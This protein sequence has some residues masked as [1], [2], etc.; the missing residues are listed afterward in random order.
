MVGA[1]LLLHR[2]LRLRSS[3]A[4][5]SSG[6]RFPRPA[7]CA[8]GV[9]RSRC[10]GS[11]PR[12][13]WFVAEFGRQPW[14]V[15]GVLPTAMAVS[16]PVGARRCCITLA[17]FVAF[18]TVLFVIEMGLMLQVHPQGP[19]QDVAATDAWMDAHQRP[20]GCRR[21]QRSPACGVTPMIL[22]RTHRLRRPAR[23]LVGAAR[24]AADRLRRSPTASTW[25]SARCCPSSAR[26]TRNAASP[27][28]PSARSGKAT[29]SGSS[30]AAAPSSPPGRRSMR[31]A[32]RASIWRCSSSWPRSSCGR[33]ASST[34]PSAT[35]AAWRNG[36]D[37]ALFVGGA[38]PALIFGVAVGNVLQGVPFRFDRRPACVFYD[39]SRSSACSTR[40]R[41]SPAWCRCR[42]WSCTAPPG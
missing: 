15:D 9:H 8:R 37:W 22:H 36:W 13:G 7:L 28:T 35:S 24:R 30:S 34:A 31:S 38:V 12:L 20:P 18:Y 40:S 14:M 19:V 26:P 25:A 41:C 5:R 2:R 6:M 32:S 27:S 11:P 1:R 29:R 23:D 39:G 3:A 10:R 4:P 21:S 42:C 17:G 33:S 16:Q